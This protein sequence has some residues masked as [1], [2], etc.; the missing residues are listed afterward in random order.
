VGDVFIGTGDHLRATWDETRSYA[1]VYIPSEQFVRI[2]L[3]LLSGQTIR[4]WW[5]NP[6]S[7]ATT[8]IGEFSK[9]AETEFR[10]PHDTSGRDWILILDDSAKNYPPPGTKL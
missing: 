2:N 7:G 8:P 9:K 5:F 1:M 10:P 4:A 3:G 6:R